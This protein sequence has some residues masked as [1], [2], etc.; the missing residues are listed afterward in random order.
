MRFRLDRRLGALLAAVFVCVF[1]AFGA[2]VALPSSDRSLQPETGRKL[3]KQAMH[4]MRL[5]RSEGCWYCHTQQ[6]RPGDDGLGPLSKP[7]D[8]A[9]DRPAMIGAERV[10]P[11]LAH[12]GS[13]ITARD[14]LVKILREP[15]ARSPRSNMPSYAY[16]SSSE[17]DALAA[18]LLALQ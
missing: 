9:T 13:R 16:L 8:Y 18:Y 6:V 2:T 12:V 3:S 1:V 5:Y 17:L 4:G 7:A 15:R 11:D 14:E 10:G